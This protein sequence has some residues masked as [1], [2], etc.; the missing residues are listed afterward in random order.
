MFSFKVIEYGCGYNLLY[1]SKKSKL[2]QFKIE[3]I[4]RYL[5]NEHASVLGEEFGLT[6]SAVISFLKKNGV[7]VRAPKE[8]NAIR[9]ATENKIRSKQKYKKCTKCNIEKPLT[10]KF[11]YN[12]AHK[13]KFS[14]MCKIC[15]S[16][17]NSLYHCN[18]KEKV[19]KQNQEYKKNNIEK[20]NLYKRMYN[21]QKY[22]ADPNNKIRTVIS[23]AIRQGLIRQDSSK[24]GGLCMDFL[25][26]TIEELK[27]H[28]ESKFESWMNWSNYGP[29]RKTWDDN[30]QLTWTW[31]IDHIIPHSMFIYN[32]M[33]D[34]EFKKCWSI[35]NLRPLC[36]KQNCIDGV[37]RLRHLNILKEII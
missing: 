11:F 9:I 20:I 4:N 10:N 23:K 3:V 12:R 24:C 30:N 32:S 6:G 15:G 8:A 25:Q 34:N 2:E 27:R 22:H 33:Q 13:T 1:M 7:I 18:N 16:I 26:F 28:L 36:S 29:Y 21:K 31:Q 14:P 35:E 37:L 17:Y 19:S 5:N